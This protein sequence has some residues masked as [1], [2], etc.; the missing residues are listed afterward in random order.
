MDITLTEKRVKSMEE[1]LIAAGAYLAVL[2]HN[3]LLTEEIRSELKKLRM[4]LRSHLIEIAC[5][6]VVAEM[7]GKEAA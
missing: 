5:Q 3:I 7:G 1:D 2:S 4:R 6:R